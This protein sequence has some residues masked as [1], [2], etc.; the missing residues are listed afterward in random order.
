MKGKLSPLRNP[1]SPQ[2]NVQMSI[3]PVT[4]PTVCLDVRTVYIHWRTWILNYSNGGVTTDRVTTNTTAA[5]DFHISLI[6][7]WGG[8]NKKNLKNTTLTF[9]AL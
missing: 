8:K 4:K 6:L 9:L 1:F 5:K 7:K 3:V 2:K